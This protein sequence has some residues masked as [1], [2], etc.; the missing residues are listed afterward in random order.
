MFRLQL[1]F[2]LRVN[3]DVY[4]KIPKC[5]SMPSARG[6]REKLNAWIIRPLPLQKEKE[7]YTV[8]NNE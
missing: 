7:G 3:Q 1:D 6:K 8:M 5:L 4:I 2:G